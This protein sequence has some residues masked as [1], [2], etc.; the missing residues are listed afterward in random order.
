MRSLSG[1][2]VCS[3][4]IAGPRGAL[5]RV[6]QIAEHKYCRPQ[7]RPFRLGFPRKVPVFPICSPVVL[8]HA[9]GTIV[10]GESFNASLAVVDDVAEVFAAVID[11]GWA[12]AGI[13]GVCISR[14]THAPAST[15]CT[16]ALGGL[17]PRRGR[18]TAHGRA[19]YGPP[20]RPNSAEGVRTQPLP[21]VPRKEGAVHPRRDPQRQASPSVGR[22]S[23]SAFAL[24]CRDK[25]RRPD[26]R[27]ASASTFEPA[28]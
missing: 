3:V 23:S 6:A 18:E 20:R 2:P 14:L 13:G 10:G 4:S 27:R 12:L 11:R 22:K 25:Y 19:P 26:R 24:A 15:C 9:C 21:I 28:A 17:P 1:G 7:A 8:E 5:D 16:S